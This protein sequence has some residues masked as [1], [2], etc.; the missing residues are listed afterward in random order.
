MNVL[1]S[2]SIR[3]FIIAN[4]TVRWR[5]MRNTRVWRRRNIT[6]RQLSGDV[7]VIGI[8]F[9]G[10]G[11]TILWC[12]EML[13]M[14]EIRPQHGGNL[15]FDFEAS[16]G[17]IDLIVGVKVPRNLNE[18]VTAHDLLDSFDLT[19]CKASF[20]GTTFQIP[21]L[22]LLFNRKTTMEFSCLIL[23]DSYTKHYNK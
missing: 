3:T 17:T 4:I 9:V 12:G 15:P 23:L 10:N 1:P 7:Y 6:L 20:D 18:T 11:E 2:Q 8:T 14:C 19:I 13:T 22:H 21:E 16:H 5:R